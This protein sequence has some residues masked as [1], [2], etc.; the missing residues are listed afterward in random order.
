MKKSSFS[1]DDI[2]TVIS[3]LVKREIDLK[4]AYIEK[5]GYGDKLALVRFANRIAAFS[6]LY[7]VFKEEA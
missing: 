5:N 2:C 4:N 3:R 6:E 7:G 1:Y